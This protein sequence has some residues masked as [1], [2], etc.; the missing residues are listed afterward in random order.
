[1]WPCVQLHRKIHVASRDA[2]GGCS[3]RIRVDQSERYEAE[4]SAVR[5]AL[6]EANGHIALVGVL[7]FLLY[8]AIT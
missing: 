6:D 4:L 2:G 1:M 8:H 3:Q 5:S 7:P